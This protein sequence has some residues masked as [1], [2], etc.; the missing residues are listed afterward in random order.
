MLLLLEMVE[1]NMSLPFLQISP[2]MLT[3]IKSIPVLLWTKLKHQMIFSHQSYV[4]K[5]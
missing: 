4:L 5:P 2:C 3:I 1:N